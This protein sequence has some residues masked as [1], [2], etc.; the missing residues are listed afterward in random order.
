MSFVKVIQGQITKDGGKTSVVVPGHPIKTWALRHVVKK[1]L[2][3]GWEMRQ[4]GE[5]IKLY[6]PNAER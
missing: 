4:Q 2:T 6:S 1:H 3:K 5:N